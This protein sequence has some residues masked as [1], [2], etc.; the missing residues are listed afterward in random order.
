MRDYRQSLMTAEWFSIK[1]FDIMIYKIVTEFK[2]R[3]IYYSVVAIVDRNQQSSPLFTFL[4][5]P[6]YVKFS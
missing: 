1:G 5:L 2:I 4:I 6:R 3:S